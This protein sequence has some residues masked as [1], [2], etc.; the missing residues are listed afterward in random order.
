MKN[1]CPGKKKVLSDLGVLISDIHLD[2]ELKCC[3][4]V[5]QDCNISIELETGPLTK[6]LRQRKVLKNSR[7]F[8]N[9]DFE[10]GEGVARLSFHY[11][12]EF[13][14]LTELVIILQIKV[15]QGTAAALILVL[16]DETES[17]F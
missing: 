17:I 2:L 3:R 6:G 5:T 12:N 8:R 16:R 11:I 1:I 7:N 14:E 9:K 4:Y 15:E 13:K 10:F